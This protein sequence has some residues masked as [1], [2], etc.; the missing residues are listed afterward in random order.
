[1]QHRRP[2]SYLI[3]GGVNTVFGYFMTIALYYLLAPVITIVGVGAL[4]VVINISFSFLTYKL[5]VF[6]TKGHWLS[7]YLRAFAVSGVSI[8]VSMAAL[9]LLVDRMHVSIWIAQGAIMA[10]VIALTYLAHSHFTF[11]G[12]SSAAGG[13]SVD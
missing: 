4:A 13:R 8:A 7:E 5:F 10:V 3:A 11:R 1:V 12:A 2:L 6:K 9:W